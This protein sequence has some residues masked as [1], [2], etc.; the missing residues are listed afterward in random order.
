MNSVGLTFVELDRRFRR[1]EQTAKAEEAALASY[2]GSLWRSEGLGW[3]DVLKRSRVVILGEPG[4]GKTWEFRN[5]A[6]LL[7]G[8]G[9]FAFLIPLER[10]ATETTEMALGS[11]RF[12]RF[13]HWKDGREEASFF[14]DSVDEAKFRKL[15]NFYTALDR[16]RD[17]LGSDALSRARIF[18]SSRI[19]EWQPLNDAYELNQRFPPPPSAVRIEDHKNRGD[20]NLSQGLLVVQLDPLDREQVE[21]FAVELRVVNTGKFIDALDRNH[22]WE[23]ARRPLDVSELLFFWNEKTRLGSLTEIIEFDVR[24]KLQSRKVRDDYPLSDEEASTGAEWLAAAS[25][26]SR[27][28]VFKVPEDAPSGEDSLDPSLCLPSHWR[29]EE[30]RAL[31]GRALFD[32]ATYGRIRFHHRS[33][34][35]FLAARWLAKRVDAGCPIYDLENLLV[36]NIRGAK[37]LRP[38][39]SP[40]AAWLCCGTERWNQSV[41]AWVLECEPSIHLKY[42]DP[43]S[44]PVDY[45]RDVLFALFHQ[46]KGRSRMWLDARPECLSRLADPVLSANISEFIRDP[47]LSDDFRIQML[48]IAIHGRLEACLDAALDI[49]ADPVASERVKSNA[50]LLIDAVGDEVKR[51]RLAPI[52]ATMPQIPAL[53]GVRIAMAIFPKAVSAM[54]LVQLLRKTDFEADDSIGLLHYL[55]AHFKSTV[56]PEDAGSLIREVLALAQTPPLASYGQETSPIS[57]QFTWACRLLPTIFGILVEKTNL[58]LQEIA[59]AAEAAWLIGYFREHHGHQVSGENFTNLNHST[60]KHPEIRRVHFWRIVNGIRE[61]SKAELN[62]YWFLTSPLAVLTMTPQDFSWL[63]EDANVRNESSDRV[64]ALDLALLLWIQ[65]GRSRADRRQILRVVRAQPSL[66]LPIFHKCAASTR[67]F[68]FR[69]F[70][71]RHLRNRIG[72]SMWWHR[73][74]VRFKDWLASSRAHA[75][76]LLHLRTLASG[77]PIN[78]LALMAREADPKNTNQWTPTTWSGLEK[79]RGKLIASAVRRGCKAAW[80]RFVPELPHEKSDQSKIDNRIVIG[81]AGLQA[82]IA[83]G[84]MSLAAL[85]D[86]EAWLAARYAVNELNGFPPWIDDLAKAHPSAVCRVLSAC[87]GG[88]WQLPDGQ[89]VHLVLYDLAWYGET[90]SPLAESILLGRLRAGDPPNLS[91][92]RFT[93]IA[94]TRRQSPLLRQVSEIAASRISGLT[95]PERIALWLAVWMQI[96]ADAAIQA[97]RQKTVNSSEASKIYVLLCAMLS[98]ESIEREPLIPNPDY[99]RTKILRQLIPLVYSRVKIS[100]DIDRVGKGMFTPGPRDHAQHF[101][102]F[103]LD[104]LAKDE[105]PEAEDALSELANDPSMTDTKEW[106]LDL[107]DKRLKAQADLSAWTPEDLRTFAQH[108]EVDPKNDKELFS[109]VRKRLREIKAEVEQADNSMRRELHPDYPEAELRKWLQRKLTDRSR[110]RYTVPQEEEIDLQQ[111]PDLRIERP[112]MGPVSIEVK[113]AE[114]W[115]LL[116]LLERLENQLVGQY[117]RAHDSQYGIYVLGIIGSKG[118]WVGPNKTRRTFEEVVTLVSESARNLVKKRPDIG[119][120]EVISIDFREPARN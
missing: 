112:G 73:I 23:F 4:S 3:E 107:L 72:N 21:H 114:R 88:E 86:E 18:L 66:L 7:T 39:L 24:S 104:R 58:S 59:V 38:A 26:L 70:W 1:L 67:F 14:L 36:S 85:T 96:D 90:L 78:W 40:I 82:G 84:E 53:L 48:E 6:E 105:S 46:S 115:T 62:I 29:N 79:K 75:D 113:W 99:L 117:L 33:V 64:L 108:H 93:L 5:R 19:S 9:E 15:S 118:Y 71:Q 91:I 34:A 56:A 94:L 92:L 20:D 76:L 51:S 97:L 119:D 35:E 32:S 27:K 22:A 57:A 44:L 45:R 111:R 42:G 74:F 83:D 63:L 43:G 41:R 89:Q 103:L 55:N 47:S 54:Q 109:I 52:V 10:L 120:L 11:D 13:K 87:I 110:Q 80:R 69:Q 98:R 50:V 77:K 30:S 81:L 68:R 95:K 28:F 101:R 31:L 61:R 100:E 2:R 37:V 25:A 106:I 116:D 16:F 102:S 12:K 49:V 65:R 17:A 8:K 60:L